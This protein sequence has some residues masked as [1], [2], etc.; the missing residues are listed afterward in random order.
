MPFPRL[1]SLRSSSN[2]TPRPASRV[3]VVGG[4]FADSIRGTFDGSFLGS[5]LRSFGGRL[6]GPFVVGLALSGCMPEFTTEDTLVNSPRILAVRSE[7]AEARPGTAV[8]LHALVAGTTDAP[9]WELCR[10]R[11]RL[12]ESGPVAAA[13]FSEEGNRVP[14]GDGFVVDATWPVDACRVFGPTPPSPAPG[15][16]S[17][18]GIDPD[19][20]GGF[21][22]P[23]VLDLPDA[24]A[25]L[26][27]PRLTCAPVGASQPVIVEYNR[28]RR[29]NENPLI[30]SLV[31][32]VGESEI[33]AS[34]ATPESPV[35]V[36]SGA[37]IRF[38]LTWP[39]CPTEPVCGDGICDVDEGVDT[40]ESDCR[41]PKGC[42]GAERYVLIDPATRRVVVAE[43]SLR[44]SWFS[45]AGHFERAREKSEEGA[46]GA[47]NVWTAPESGEHTVWVVLRDDRG[48]VDW[49]AI[50]VSIS[51]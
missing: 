38:E 33:D 39:Q 6:F 9:T 1:P 32:H 35:T 5:L 34:E 28:R 23:L 31:A 49:R 51:Q 25:T 46:E 29:A 36:P 2:R 14:L 10:E 3:A 4:S 12:D 7:P 24:A 37:E 30:A 18:R 27:E 20:T 17:G 50:A 21:S 15:E 19:V 44:I 43:E 11:P 42:G 22:V 47:R 48:G 45:T 26:A 13:C 16:S 41:T 8:R 40:C